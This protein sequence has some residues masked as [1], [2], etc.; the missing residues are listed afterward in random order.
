MENTTSMITMIA[1]LITS[2]TA[3]IAIVQLRVMK[4]TFVQDH[5]RSRREKAIEYIF[6]WVRYTSRGTA[7]KGIVERLDESQCRKLWK[8]QEFEIDIKYKSYLERGIEDF[9]VTETSITGKTIIIDCK[10]SALI[11]KDAIAYLNLIEMILAAAYNGVADKDIIMAE[12]ASLVCEEKNM[13]LLTNLRKVAGGKK[14]FPYI[15]E[16]VNET[17]CGDIVKKNTLGQFCVFKKSKK[18]SK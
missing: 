8:E 15:E 1:T 3:F 11:R 4:K 18:Y 12:F 9:G 13:H 5:E 6:E 14:T 16:F 7:A 10:Q 2:I 17:K